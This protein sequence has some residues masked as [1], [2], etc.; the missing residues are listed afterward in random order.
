MCISPANSCHV[1]S[2]DGLHTSDE[3]VKG[4]ME[5]PALRNVA[6]LRLMWKIP[7]RP[8]HNTVTTV[9]PPT[10]EEKMDMGTKLGQGIQ[11]VN[12]ARL[13]SRSTA[14]DLIV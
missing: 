3:K 14:L 2:A 5:A 8:R 9:H 1:I 4:Y 11:V 13:F 6:K 7:A 12:S 10:E